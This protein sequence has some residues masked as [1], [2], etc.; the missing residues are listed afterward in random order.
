M[1]DPE[2]CGC[3]PILGV[4]RP[5][6][7]PSMVCRATK[8]IRPAPDFVPRTG[9]TDNLPVSTAI[10]PPDERN[11]PSSPQSMVI[12]AVAAL[13]KPAWWGGV[14]GKTEATFKD[15]LLTVSF[16]GSAQHL[17]CVFAGR[18]QKAVVSSPQAARWRGNQIC[19]SLHQ[20]PS[21][22]FA[23]AVMILVRFRRAESGG[24]FRDII[25]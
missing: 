10:S 15:L 4:L 16:R 5:V 14:S 18:R 19:W 8:G 24:I 1:L 13:P 25:T 2:T 22:D 11:S 3:Y 17:S 23:E 7:R 6:P 9:C 12:S 20:V 21:L